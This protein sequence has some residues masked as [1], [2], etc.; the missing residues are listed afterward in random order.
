MLYEQIVAIEP[1]TCI[2]LSEYMEQSTSST[3][4]MEQYLNKFRDMVGLLTVHR[5]T[6]LKS[7]PLFQWQGRTSACWKFEEHRI[8]HAL[9]AMIM[10]DAKKCFDNCDY[11]GAKVLLGRAVDVAKEM[12]FVDWCKTPGVRGMPELQLPYLMSVLFRTKGTYYFTM[13][14]FKSNKVAAKT[15]YQYVELSNCLWRSSADQAYAAKMKAHYHYAFAC[16][17]DN[18]KEIISHSTAAVG[19]LQD[20]K[21]L[22][23][24]TV[25]VEQNNTVHY[26]TVEDVTCPTIGVEFALS[27]V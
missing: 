27:K 20:P 22:E 15:A 10:T 26:E 8:M 16:E 7:Q 13:H 4:S 3:E 11:K 25:W 17:S 1:T 5:R 12:L 9:H 18:F 21:M 19:L 24:H 6:P 2:A 14:S 23:D